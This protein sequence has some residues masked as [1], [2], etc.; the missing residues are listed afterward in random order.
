ME[1]ASA[2]TLA[3]LQGSGVCSGRIHIR[4]D[5]IK[6]KK[7]K[8]I[9]FRVPADRSGARTNKIRVQ[10][11]AKKIIFIFCICADARK[12]NYFSRVYADGSASMQMLACPR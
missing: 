12:K 11:D 9:L 8:K 3:R 1:V 2:R 4:A 7:E 10:A 5:A 6:K